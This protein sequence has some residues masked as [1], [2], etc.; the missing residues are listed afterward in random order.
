MYPLFNIRNNEGLRLV[1]S[2]KYSRSKKIVVLSA[3]NSIPGDQGNM[4]V[5]IGPDCLE[6]RVN[7]VE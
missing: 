3:Q 7:G 2:D 6:E 4:A 1:S 5:G